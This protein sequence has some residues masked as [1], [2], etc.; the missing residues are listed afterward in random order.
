MGLRGDYFI[1]KNFTVGGTLMRLSERPMTTTV[2][3]GY[4]P[5][6][7][8]VA[9]LDVNYQSESKMITRLL[10]K[11]PIFSSTMPSFVAF[12]AEVA[13]IFPGHHKLIDGIDPEGSIAL[14]NFEGALSESDIEALF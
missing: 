5:I 4:D 8:T 3:Y 7:N 2:Q 10:D 11:L 14:D 1:N 9:G 6:K 12:K 13:G